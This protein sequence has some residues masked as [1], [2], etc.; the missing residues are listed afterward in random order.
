MDEL[1]GEVFFFKQK[2]AYEIKECDWSS[3][4]CSSDLEF[5]QLKTDSRIDEYQIKI[6]FIGR[7]HLFPKDVKEKMYYLM[8]KTKNNNGSII[9]FAMAYGGREEVIDAVKKV[10]EQIKQGNLSVD[11]INEE[12]FSKNLYTEDEPDLIIRTGG[13]HRTSNRSEERRVGKECRS[14]WSP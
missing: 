8:D 6:N 13:D 2:T 5:E 1:V 9:N 14:S 4:V 11:D 3:D 12:S 10:A 7:I